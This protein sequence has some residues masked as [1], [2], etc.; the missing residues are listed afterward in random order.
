MH[1]S[2]VW[3]VRA[4]TCVSVC[5]PPRTFINVNPRLPSTTSLTNHECNPLLQVL[6]KT[7]ESVQQILHSIQEGQGAAAVG[8][9]RAAAYA[10]DGAPNS[11]SNSSSRA[12]SGTPGP[13]RY[14]ELTRRGATAAAAAAPNSPAEFTDLRA[15]G[16]KG[17]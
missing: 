7:T 9:G 1:V 5:P 13:G 12:G 6:R 2:S 15:E 4:C 8:E 16:K 17:Q 11:S 10:V 3:P 14:T